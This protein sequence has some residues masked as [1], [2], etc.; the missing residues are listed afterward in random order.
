MSEI[1]ESF[2]SE[3]VKNIARAPKY[4]GAIFQV[5]ADERGLALI[6][7]KELINLM[8]EYEV[9]V[10]RKE[11]PLFEVQASLLDDVDEAR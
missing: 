7:G 10:R 9:G 3:K 11:V 8:L 2:V 5:E 1:S 6:D 4:R